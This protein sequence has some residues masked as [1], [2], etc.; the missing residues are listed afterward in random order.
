MTET[1]AHIALNM[2]PRLG[3]VRLRRLLAAFD[4]PQRILAASASEL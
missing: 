2:V 1:E 4:T 3:P